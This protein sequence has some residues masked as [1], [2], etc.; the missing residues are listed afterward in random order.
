MT[1]NATA[2]MAAVIR[3]TPRQRIRG[4]LAGT[5]ARAGREGGAGRAGREAVLIGSCCG[6]DAVLRVLVMSVFL[7]PWNPCGWMP[8]GGKHWS[9]LLV[10]EHERAHRAQA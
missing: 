4:R 1:P 8:R 9:Y 2:S 7:V 3:S 5:V 6:D 10:P